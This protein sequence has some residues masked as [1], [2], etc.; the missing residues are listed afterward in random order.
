M[1][2][3]DTRDRPVQRAIQELQES[4]VCQV[5]KEGVASQDSRENQEHL[6]LR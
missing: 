4:V 2:S 5:Q 6:D 1:D 3:L